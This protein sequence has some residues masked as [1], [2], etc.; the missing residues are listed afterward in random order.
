MCLS[1]FLVSPV[2]V[3]RAYRTVTRQAEVYQKPDQIEF[4]GSE[5]PE[6]SRYYWVCNPN[7]YTAC[8]DQYTVTVL[9]STL[10]VPVIFRG[11]LCQIM[12]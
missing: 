11:A 8:T 4:R 3:G 2:A 6:E 7:Q 9:I 10:T 12:Q 1:V 5:A